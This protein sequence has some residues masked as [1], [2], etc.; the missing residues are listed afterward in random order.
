MGIYIEGH[1]KCQLCGDAILSAPV[2]FPPMI[3]NR[4]DR[5][6][7]YNDGFFHQACLDASA[8][9]Q[10]I[11]RLIEKFDTERPMPGNYLCLSCG[12]QITKP[13]DCLGLG[14]LSPD[15]ESALSDF[16]FKMIHLS[17]LSSEDVSS[18]RLVKTLVTEIQEGRF[19]ND[20]L[21]R[22]LRKRGLL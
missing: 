15:E 12:K 7:K 21:S 9:G 22:D 11:K 18:V 2:G 4:L 16:N 6:S 20:G 13:D 1:T 5:R 10:E 3:A 17:C 19:E 8:I 14:L